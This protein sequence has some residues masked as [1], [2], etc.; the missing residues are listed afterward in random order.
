LP[1]RKKTAELIHKS[2][3]Y[4]YQSRKTSTVIRRPDGLGEFEII[5]QGVQNAR[6]GRPQTLRLPS[7]HANDLFSLTD[8]SIIKKKGTHGFQKGVKKGLFSFLLGFWSEFCPV[9]Q[10][11]KKS[12][13]G[14]SWLPLLAIF[15]CVL[16][17]QSHLAKSWVSISSIL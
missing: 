13:L 6:K 1:S 7:D 8:I 14:F 3:R 17:V 15:G 5:A 11:E 4:K 9:L 2:S 10:N 16:A 12:L